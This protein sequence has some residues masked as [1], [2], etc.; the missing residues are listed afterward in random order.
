[1]QVLQRSLPRPMALT[2]TPDPLPAGPV[3]PSPVE[4]AERL[5]AAEV[6]ALRQHDA[7]A[8]PLKKRKRGPGEFLRTHAQ[9]SCHAAMQSALLMSLML[10]KLFWNTAL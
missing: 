5:L 3:G 7:A 6:N 2:M 1:M 10:P 4:A 8:Y 9:S